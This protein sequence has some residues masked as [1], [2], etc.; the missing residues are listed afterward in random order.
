MTARLRALLDELEA[1][2][3][4]M[5]SPEAMAESLRAGATAEELDDAEARLGHPLSDEARTFYSW[6]NGVGGLG[7]GI[8]LAPRVQPLHRALRLTLGTR[9]VLNEI[10]DRQYA[11]REV[12]WS[13]AVHWADHGGGPSYWLAGNDEVSAVV[14]WDS[15]QQG[16]SMPSITDLIELQVQSLASGTWSQDQRGRWTNSAVDDIPYEQQL[17]GWLI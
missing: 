6:H 9:D 16:L 2:L 14:M 1:V 17:F 5:T 10:V 13:R 7:W 15:G 8:P 3:A 12:D 11:D 4:E